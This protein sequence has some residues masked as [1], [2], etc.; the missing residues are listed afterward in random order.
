MGENGPDFCNITQVEESHS[1]TCLIFGLN[2]KLW[3]KVIPRF[4]TVAL[5]V[6][7]MPSREIKLPVI[8]FLNCSVPRNYFP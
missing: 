1:E 7:V 6:K 3:S 5:E 4:V 2:D 8:E